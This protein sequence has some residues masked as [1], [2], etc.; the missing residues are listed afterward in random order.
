MARRIKKTTSFAVVHFS[1]AFTVSYLL[2]GSAVIAGALALIEPMVN[3]VAF[4]VHD[5]SW[6]RME[7]MRAASDAGGM[8]AGRGQVA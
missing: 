4:F 1:V 7:R 2:T 5:W 6:E 8:A 3:T